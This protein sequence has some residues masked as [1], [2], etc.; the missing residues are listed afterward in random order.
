MFENATTAGVKMGGLTTNTEIRVMLCYLLSNVSGPLKKEEIDASLSGQELANFFEVADALS[1]LCTR[2]LVICEDEVYTISDEGR[3][4]AKELEYTLPITVREC[5]VKAA[6]KLQ[7]YNRKKAEYHATYSKTDKGYKVHC[8][9]EDL[10]DTIFS[11][12]IYMPD[13]NTAKQAETMFAEHGDKFFTH[14]LFMLTGQ[15]LLPEEN[16]IKLVK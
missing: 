4:L 2:K 1:H 15:E 7:A 3:S 14:M 11:L 16:N 13:E 8:S 5:A 10:G 12:D 9:I 6:I